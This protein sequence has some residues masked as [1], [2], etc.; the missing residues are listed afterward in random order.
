MHKAT[1][2]S[3]GQIT[4]PADVRESL[5]LK[6]GDKI[7]FL[8][9]EKGEFRVRK[10]RSILDLAGCIPYSGPPI[11]P[12]EMDQAIADHV[13]A[14]DEATMSPAGRRRARKARRQAA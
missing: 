4:L 5:G 1:L 2:T 14:L 10:V 3:K 9:G 11:S 8:P 13:A 7:L 6:A 12:Q